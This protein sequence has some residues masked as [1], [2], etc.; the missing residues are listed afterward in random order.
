MS[1]IFTKIINREIL[2]DII[3]EDS[4]FIAFLDVNPLHDGHTLVIPKKEI[5]YIFDLDDET[6]FS[7]METSKKIA[8]IIDERLKSK[9]NFKRVGI[10]V[11]GFGVPH[12][13][14]HLI[15]LTDSFDLQIKAKLE[16]KDTY[17]NK[18]SKEE[19]KQIL[20]GDN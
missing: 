1:S 18:M 19:I 7:L 17:R 6:Y 15:P 11:E 4:N 5:D 13:H 9:L 2:A 16:N 10:I 14:V 3:Y 20:L 8:K 12:V